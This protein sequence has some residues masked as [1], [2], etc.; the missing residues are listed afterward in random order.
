MKF[1]MTGFEPFGGDAKNPSWEAVKLLKDKYEGYDVVKAL[2]PV[3]F[4]GSIKQLEK[5]IEVHAPDVVVCVGLSGGRKEISIE[6]IGINIDD[7]RIADNSG[8]SPVDI[9]IRNDG[10]AAY[11]SNLP[12]KAIVNAMRNQGIAAI[13]SN[14][15][16]TFVC[17]HVLYGVMD[18][19]KTKAPNIRGGFI[20]V[21]YTMDFSKAYPELPVMDLSEIVKGLEVAIDCI[22]RTNVDL[23]VSEGTLC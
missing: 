18:Y 11:F 3:T 4:D 21:P 23:N 9:P 1:L 19:I 7:A 22:A 14:T 13:V 16:G 17:N 6:R 20:H 2:I 5:L 15:A 12:I 8:F 10:P